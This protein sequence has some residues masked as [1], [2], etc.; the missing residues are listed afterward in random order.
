MGDVVEFL[1]CSHQDAFGSTVIFVQE[2]PQD[3]V[4][5]LCDQEF[6]ASPDEELSVRRMV[7]ATQRM[8]ES[9]RQLVR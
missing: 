1:T 6:P 3:G 8:T 9:F 5:M 7:R 4:C 2:R